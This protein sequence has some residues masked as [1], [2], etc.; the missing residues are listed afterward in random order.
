MMNTYR[1]LLDV[2]EPLPAMSRRVHKKDFSVKQPAWEVLYGGRRRNRNG[3]SDMWTVVVWGGPDHVP[4]AQEVLMLST[5]RVTDA[6]LEVD[7]VEFTEAAVDVQI[8]G[9]AELPFTRA[10]I[11]VYEV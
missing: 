6:L 7:G 4:N 10:T 9:L 8:P 3:W 11:D 1:R 5:Q 2:L